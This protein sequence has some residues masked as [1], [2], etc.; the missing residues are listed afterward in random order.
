M[1]NPLIH[2]KPYGGGVAGKEITITFPLEKHFNVKRVFVVLR[3]DE[4]SKRIELPYSHTAENVDFFEAK[5]VIDTYGIWH[6]RFEGVHP[7]ATLAFFGR[8]TD[9]TAI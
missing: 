5:F 1:Y 3:K 6:Y 2:K 4:V 9:G 8:D 7:D